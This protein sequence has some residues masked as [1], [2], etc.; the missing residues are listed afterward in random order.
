MRHFLRARFAS[1]LFLALFSPLANAASGLGQDPVTCTKEQRAIK[2]EGYV[3]LGGIEQWVTVKGDDCR[4][5]VILFIHG[6]PGNPNTPFAHP[7]YEAWE[8]DF[9]LVQW[10]QRGAGKTFARNPSTAD[11]RL[12]LDGMARDGNELAAYLLTH[13]HVKKV[14]LFGGSWGSVLSVHMAKSRPELF[15]AYLG[16][17]Q[18]VKSP[19]NGIAGYRAL[20]ALAR[21]A[22]DS[23]TVAAL[24]GL[25]EPPWTNPRA[26]GIMRR[27]S[28]VYE[29]KTTTASPKT[30]WTLAPDYATPEAQAA[31]EAGEDYSFLQ[32]VGMKGDGMLAS[33]DV[34]KLGYDFPMPV[35]MVQ[36]AQDLITVPEI[37]KRYFDAIHSPHKEYFLLPKVGHDPNP[38]MIA[39]QFAI[40]KNKIAPMLR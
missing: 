25:G 14:I 12:T 18:L 4:N 24:E 39:S 8:K 38:D 26:F 11:G 6:G 15:G 40:L 13:L 31:Y 35:F 27:A 1:L 28:R 37:S 17:G 9:T 10:D 32:F 36:G 7:P 16:T 2:E 21:E 19:E 22:G 34:T 29:A 3:T 23:P 33:V 30:W 20:L 5:P